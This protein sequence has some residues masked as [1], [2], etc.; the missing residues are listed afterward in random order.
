[1]TVSAYTSAHT[2][3]NLQHA[4]KIIIYRYIWKKK[5]ICSYIKYTVIRIRTAAVNYYNKV[6]PNWVHTHF[7]RLLDII[8]D[9][10][11][12][13]ARHTLDEFT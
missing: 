10:N 7:W 9:Y 1:M 4:S 3:Y 2:Y 13:R 5:K 11:N 6:P 12:I 8:Y